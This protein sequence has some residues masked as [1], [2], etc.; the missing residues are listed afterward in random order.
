MDHFQTEMYEHP[1]FTPAERKAKW[2]ELE[3][4]YRPWID[5]EDLPFFSVGGG[6]QRQHHIYSYPLYYIDYCLAQT[7]A[8]EFW[9]ASEK[10]WTEA[11]SRYLSFVHA[12]GTKT[13][14]ELVELASLELPFNDGCLRKVGQAV[15]AYLTK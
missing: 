8:L 12:G 11:F 15:D 5:F 3:R 6:Y 10:D 9:A 13:Y 2:L 7:T 14:V 4:L 1:E